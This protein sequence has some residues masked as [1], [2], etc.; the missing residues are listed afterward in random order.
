[1]KPTTAFKALTCIRKAKHLAEHNIGDYTVNKLRKDGSVGVCI[2]YHNGCSLSNLETA[3]A[4]AEKL[5]QLNPNS[6]FVV[7]RV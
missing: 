3:Q 4:R 7:C 1:M 5:N 2:K 6:K